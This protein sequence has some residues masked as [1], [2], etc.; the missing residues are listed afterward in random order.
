[1]NSTCQWSA[2]I[3]K[4]FKPSVFLY[5]FVF[6]YFCLS[7]W[8]PQAT[9]QWSVAI[10]KPFK[11]SFSASFNHKMSGCTITC[12]EVGCSSG[13]FCLVNKKSPPLQFFSQVRLTWILLGKFRKSALGPCCSWAIVYDL[14]WILILIP[15]NFIKN[16]FEFCWTFFCVC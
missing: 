16:A 10:W 8:I 4:P 14:I 5:F 6:L 3:P 11:A 9:Y 7:L 13:N 2:A 15:K 1:M 12:R